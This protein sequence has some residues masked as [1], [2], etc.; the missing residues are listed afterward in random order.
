MRQRHKNRLRL[1][2]AAASGLFWEL[3]WKLAGTR[4]LASDY[5]AVPFYPLQGGKPLDCPHT[6]T[7]PTWTPQD[8]Y[9][10]EGHEC[11]FSEWEQPGSRRG[12]GEADG[13]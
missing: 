5:P 4:W 13:T 7:Y 12:G 1:F 9:P 11:T 3:M 8:I 2:W 6:G 10:V